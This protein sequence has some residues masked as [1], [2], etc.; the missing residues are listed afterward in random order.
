TKTKK[1]L[2]FFPPDQPRVWETGWRMGAAL[3]AAQGPA[4]AED[5]TAAPAAEG[6]GP[7]SKPRAR[8]RPHIRRAHWHSFWRGPRQGPREVVVK[9]LPPIPVAVERKAP[10]V[11]TVRQVEAGE[12]PRKP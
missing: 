2:R 6:E 5:V 12:Q 9:W 7:V 1:G 8:P 10:I 11:P 3:R 4:S